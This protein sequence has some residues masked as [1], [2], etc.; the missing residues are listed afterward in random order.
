MSDDLDVAAVAVVLARPPEMHPPPLA[1][2]PAVRRALHANAVG[3]HQCSVQVHVRMAGGV[4]GQQ[5]R[6]QLGWL[7]SQDVQ[8][9]VDVA[10]GRGDADGVVAGQ[11][12][13]LGGVE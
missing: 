13:H 5:R 11:S 8:G 1:A 10:V 12:L 6:A 7:G 3:R 9:L 4:G 2:T